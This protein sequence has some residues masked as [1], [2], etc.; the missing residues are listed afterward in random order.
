MFEEASK[1]KLRFETTR[2]LVAVE[3][4]WDIPLIGNNGFSLD[5]LAMISVVSLKIA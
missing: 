1:L 2:G 4:L 5:I 3:D